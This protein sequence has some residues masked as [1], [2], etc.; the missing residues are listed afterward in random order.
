MEIVSG[1]IFPSAARAGADAQTHELWLAGTVA[2]LARRKLTE[3]GWDIR[4]NLT[5]MTGPDSKLEVEQE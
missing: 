4:E 5:I 3:F 1:P 2:D